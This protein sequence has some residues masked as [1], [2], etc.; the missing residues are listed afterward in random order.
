[1]EKKFRYQEQDCPLTLAQGLQEY[2]EGHPGLFRPAQLSEES[3]RFFRSHDAAHVFFGL[4][5]TL[6][7]EALAD[8]WTM[9]GSDVGIRRYIGY[10]VSNPEAKQLLKEIG[11]PKTIALTF[12]AVPKALKVWLRARK[13]SQKWPW[14][15]GDG[16]RDRP[17]GQIRR[18]MNLKLLD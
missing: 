17:L 14:E 13:M 1:M 15:P 8:F 9:F 7:Q 10:L 4:D 3:A 6:D 5:T 2:Y 11:W 16:L 18:E 12:Q